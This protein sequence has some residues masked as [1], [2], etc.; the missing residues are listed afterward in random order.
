MLRENI[1]LRMAAYW[2]FEVFRGVQVGGKHLS[3][4]ELTEII[5][6]LMA[7]ELVFMCLRR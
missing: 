1:L 4:P 5:M 7:P 3:R 2:C 6:K